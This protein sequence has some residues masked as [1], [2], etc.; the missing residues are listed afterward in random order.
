VDV[1]L[2]V[3]EK[4]VLYWVVKGMTNSEIAKRLGNTGRTV[5]KHVGNIY[6]KLGVENRAAAIC[7]VFG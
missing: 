2:T 7:R 4:E 3:R 6:Q 5:E 1:G